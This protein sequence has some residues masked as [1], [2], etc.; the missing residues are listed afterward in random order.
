M[1][2]QLITNIIGTHEFFWRSM[3][4]EVY[5]KNGLFAWVTNID[6]KY[7]PAFRRFYN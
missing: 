1:N 5:D 6:N 4:I 3:A 2:K 7:L